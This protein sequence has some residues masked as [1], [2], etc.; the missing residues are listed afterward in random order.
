MDQ[1][2]NVLRCTETSFAILEQIKK[3]ETVTL[4]MLEETLDRPKSTIHRHLSTLQKLGYVS[5]SDG[6]Y[7]LSLRFLDL[8]ENA[9]T[10]YPLYSVLKPEVGDLVEET[11]ERAQVMVEENNRGIYIYQT[12]GEQAI[13]TDSHLG[14][15]VYL[16]TVASGKAYLAALSNDRIEKILDAEGLPAVTEN[17]ISEREVLFE[18]IERI[19]ERGYAFNDEEEMHGIRAVGAAICLDDGTPI[20]AV[21]LAAP[22]TRFQ[23]K[24]YRETYPDLVSDI[25][26][27]LGVKATYK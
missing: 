8:A 16:H 4:S 10:E 1:D 25:A 12:E 22:K 17:T 3:L 19:R 23:G 13:T 11:G 7:R 2:P 21:S 26:T 24:Q 14:K 6:A 20:G 5:E 27:I 15:E 9:R 18:E